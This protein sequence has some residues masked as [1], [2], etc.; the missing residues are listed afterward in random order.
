MR[1][2]APTVDSGAK[3]DD[4]LRAKLSSRAW[5]LSN[6]Y[7]IRDKDGRVVRFVPN[8]AQA[9]LDR[10]LHTLNLVLKARQRGITTWACIR[11]LDLALFRSNTAIGL[12]F[13]TLPN[14]SKAFRDKI[15]YAYDS[16]PAS[17]RGARS[18]VRRSMDGELEFSNGS[19]IRV[20]LSHRSGTLQWLHIS[21]YAKICAHDPGRANEIKTGALNTVAPG[22]YV[23]I[24][25][26]AEG[27]FGD[28]YDKCQQA[29]ALQRRIAAGTAALGP[30]D[31]KLHFLPWYE[32][33]TYQ[34]EPGPLDTLQ[35]SESKYFEDLEQVTGYELTPAQKWWYAKKSLEQGD[36]MFREYPS[37]AAEAFKAAKD[38]SYYGRQ[39]EVAEA[40][41]RVLPIPMLPHVPVHFFWDLG[42][43]DDTVLLPMQHVGDWYNWFG[44]YANNG[45]PLQH[46]IAWLQAWAAKTGAIIGRMYMP[47][48][49]GNVDYTRDDR[50]SRREVMEAAGFRVELVP[51]IEALGDGIDMVRQMLPRCR[52][53]TSCHGDPKTG[54]GLLPALRQYRKQWS[55]EAQTYRDHPMKLWANHWADAFRQCAQGYEPEK[56]V[57][58]RKR[59]TT[60]TN[61]KT[62]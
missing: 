51:R 23:C 56:Q 45:E 14:A 42:H 44:G 1:S 38:G 57:Q 3:A 12:V 17:L 53:D 35:E 28:F 26:T 39:I 7:R 33:D 4:S 30:M 15:L 29:L 32:D 21:E 25:S 18:L 59:P 20:S 43:N 6:L 34:L 46:Y 27:A 49:A 36:A 48:D 52:F 2:T 47:H 61:W 40:Q 19:T 54:H 11:A 55:E 9:H 10:N 13:D 50:K 62:A 24:E 41:G 8:E 22:N 60:S 37:T 58:A 31:Y 16:L 5:R